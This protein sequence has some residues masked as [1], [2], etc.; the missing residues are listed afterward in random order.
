MRRIQWN[1][2]NEREREGVREGV[3]V[4]KGAGRDGEGETDKI[5]RQTDR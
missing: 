5:D 4:G 2:E 3:R 1:E